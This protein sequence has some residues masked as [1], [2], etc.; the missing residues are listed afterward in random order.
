MGWVGTVP[1]QTALKKQEKMFQ[2]KLEVCTVALLHACH[3]HAHAA[4][5]TPPYRDGDR[6]TRGGQS[7]PGQAWI[8]VPFPL[9][10]SPISFSLLP[11]PFPSTGISV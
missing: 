10:P 2:F 11:S 3:A 5:S 9:L 6:Q 1:Y 8:T 4:A 7:R